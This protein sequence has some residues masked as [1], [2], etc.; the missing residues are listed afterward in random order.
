MS[1]TIHAIVAIL[2]ANDLL[3]KSDNLFLMMIILRL[4]QQNN[5]NCKIMSIKL[6]FLSTTR[7]LLNDASTFGNC[8]TGEILN[9]KLE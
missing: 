2:H 5:V 8:I 3:D 6:Q 7:S 1:F 9:Y 4:H